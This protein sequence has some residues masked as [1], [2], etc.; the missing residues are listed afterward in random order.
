MPDLFYMINFIEAHESKWHMCIV[1]EAFFIKKRHY[2]KNVVILLAQCLF[3]SSCGTKKEQ[4]MFFDSAKIYKMLPLD[5][6]DQ[7]NTQDCVKLLELDIQSG[8]IHTSF[9]K[10]VLNTVKKFFKGTK[11]VIV[12]ELDPTAL[13][14][15]GFELRIEANK[16]GG[17]QYPHFY[18]NQKIPLNAVKS[19]IRLYEDLQGNW[20]Q[21]K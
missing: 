6:F 17:T 7:T 19:T 3:L 12:L 15:N 16:P 5:N 21:E 4:V 20:L 9:G 10:Q 18:G 1:F 11:Q 13:E 8:F 14:K 2:E